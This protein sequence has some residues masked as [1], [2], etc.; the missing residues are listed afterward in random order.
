MNPVVTV[1]SHFIRTEPA[2]VAGAIG[3]VR[4]HALGEQ[5]FERLCDRDP[6]ELLQRASPEAG[7]EEVENR[8]LAPADIL[9]DRKPFLGFAA[10]ERLVLGLAGEADEIPA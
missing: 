8:M 2:A 10:V 7:V 6:P 9:A 5:A 4:H 3:F 1:F